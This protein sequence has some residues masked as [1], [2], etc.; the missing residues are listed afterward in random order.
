MRVSER[1]YEI[2]RDSMPGFTVEVDYSKYKS[3]T[4]FPRKF[5]KHLKKRA[6]TEMINR[7]FSSPFKHIRIQKYYPEIDRLNIGFDPDKLT[8]LF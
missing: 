7:G 1:V 6:L 5:K 2:P 3:Y 8:E 4:K